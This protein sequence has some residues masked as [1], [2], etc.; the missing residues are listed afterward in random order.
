MQYFLTP[1]MCLH[2]IFYTHILPYL[3]GKTHIIYNYITHVSEN[4][5][6]YNYMYV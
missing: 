5:G 4:S 6:R 3:T 2:K 1:H